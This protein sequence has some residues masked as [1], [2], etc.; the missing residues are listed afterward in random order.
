MVADN[1]LAV[2]KIVDTI[3]HSKYWKDSAIFV[4]EDDSQAGVDHVDGHRRTGYVISP[5]T[6]TGGVDSTY[7]TQVNMV[8]TIEQIL[9]LPPMNQMDLAAPP[10]TD[11]FTTKPNFA[12][13][14]V[15]ANKVPLDEMNPG[16][17]PPAGSASTSMKIAQ[18]TGIEK[19]WLDA[20]NA[21]GFNNPNTPP[22]APDHNLA[23]PRDLVRDRGL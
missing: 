19:Q 14:D 12:P 9:G 5:W 7:Y 21:M 23:E 6:K 3:S 15:V 16:S 11:L 18:P 1:D 20:S 2:G 4:T 10:M 22:D 17:T 13:Y 8:R